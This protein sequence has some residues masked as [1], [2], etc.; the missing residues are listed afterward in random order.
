M[1]AHVSGN[2]ERSLRPS[3]QIPPSM[4]SYPLFASSATL[5]TKTEGID[6][7]KKG[8]MWML[9]ITEGGFAP[10][11]RS[12]FEY[13]WCPARIRIFRATSCGES[14]NPSV[15]RVRLARR[16]CFGDD[17]HRGFPLT[18]QLAEGWVSP[19]VSNY[20]MTHQVI[21]S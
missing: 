7:E 8:N 9:G 20:K 21:C 1:L 14:K 6:A 12:V 13:F 3:A 11:P 18:Y 5:T 10:T 17:G 19:N 4:A 2:L 16:T 15:A